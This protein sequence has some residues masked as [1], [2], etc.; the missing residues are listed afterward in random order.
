MVPLSRYIWKAQ[1]FA[2]YLPLDGRVP[3]Y[4]RLWLLGS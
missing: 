3:S 4:D 2:Y 1:P